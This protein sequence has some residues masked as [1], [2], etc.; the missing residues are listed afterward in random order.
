MDFTSWWGE[1]LDSSIHSQ[2][3][4]HIHAAGVLNSLVPPIL[5]DADFVALTQGYAEFVKEPP[6][7]GQPEFISFSIERDLPLLVQRIPGSKSFCKGR[8]N[9]EVLR[10]CLSPICPE[11]AWAI[12]RPELDLD[13]SLSLPG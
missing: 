12:V 4:T 7:L 1:V 10:R 13:H 9:I 3:E 6:S 8:R 5:V 2:V 11:W